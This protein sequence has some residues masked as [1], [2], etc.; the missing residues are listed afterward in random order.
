MNFNF[1]KRECILSSINDSDLELSINESVNSLPAFISEFKLRKKECT[2]FMLTGVASK[3]DR[4]LPIG[5]RVQ[6]IDEN[7]TF[8]GKS[9]SNDLAGT[10]I[11][12]CS[13]DLSAVI[14]WRYVDT[15]LLVGGRLYRS[16]MRRTPPAVFRDIVDTSKFF[17]EYPSDFNKE[18]L[19]GIRAIIRSDQESLLWLNTKGIDFW[20]TVRHLPVV[21]EERVEL[22][23]LSF[24]DFL[25][26]HGTL[27]AIRTLLSR[28]NLD[29]SNYNAMMISA[30]IAGNAECIEYL[31]NTQR[32]SIFISDEW[33]RTPLHHAVCSNSHESVKAL[34]HESRLINARDFFG[35]SPLFF[36]K[37]E[38]M[39]R[40]L[41][42]NGA[43]DQVTDN[44]GL[45][46]YDHFRDTDR[47]AIA[48]WVASFKSR[49]VSLYDLDDSDDDDL[50]IDLITKGKIV[51]NSGIE[52]ALRRSYGFV[53]PVDFFSW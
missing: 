33:L 1:I 46:L 21:H 8:H 11:G 26:M 32:Q 18:D 9:I 37:S 36:S 49:D 3:E 48:R 38:E 24:L 43:D 30:C 53:L 19:D 31:C 15:Y 45:T 42:D 25:S 5:I 52:E 47:T 14:D 34:A 4:F 41:L 40:I 6:E 13:C 27:P 17:F 50:L 39:A 16:L 35:Y 51:D 10:E 28:L 22:T 20:T 12:D 23:D 29:E 44:N 7:W 2:S